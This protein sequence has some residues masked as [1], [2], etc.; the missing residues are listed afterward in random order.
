MSTENNAPNLSLAEPPQGGEATPPAGQNNSGSPDASTA[1]GGGAGQ[2]GG[3]KSWLETLPE[4]IK[5]DPSLAV[6]KT[7]EELAKSF[8]HAQKMI[9]ADKVVIPGEKSLPQDWENFYKKIGRPEAPEKYELPKLEGVEVEESMS[10]GFREAAF[11]AGLTPKQVADIFSWYGKDAKALVESRSAA[12]EAQFKRSYEEFEKEV[13]GKDKVMV[14]VDK[15]RQAVRLL[16]DDGLIKFLKEQRLDTHPQMIK[17]FSAMADK[18]GE[19]QI[20]GPAGA[21]PGMGAAEIQAKIDA[22]YANPAYL[23][24]DH[25]QH[26]SL[27]DEASRLFSQMSAMKQG[28]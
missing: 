25:P 23:D 10:K 4:E 26:S 9:G 15:A 22:I 1:A 27:V 5:S 8:I 16:A 24:R 18:M 11:K 12:E 19:G 21:A 2:Q 3:T 6:F 20:K 17:F 28:A 14:H 7:P 13:G